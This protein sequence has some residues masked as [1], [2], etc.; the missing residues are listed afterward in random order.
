MED[1]I[2]VLKIEPGKAPYVKEIENDYKAS[3]KEVGGLIDCF[4]F[5][6]G[7][8]AVLNDEGKISGME[9]NRRYGYDIICGPF[10]ICG[11]G[12][13]GDF[14]SLTD[15][16]AEKYSRQFGETEQFSGQEPELEPRMSFIAF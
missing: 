3:Q 13:D 7:C 10:F 1:R 15:E 6:D 8:V 16:Q 9:P 11:R 2:R 12:S 5:G 4:G 14:I